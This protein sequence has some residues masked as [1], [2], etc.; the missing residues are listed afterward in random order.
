MVRKALCL[1]AFC[2]HGQ[3]DERWC[4][5][6]ATY[7]FFWWYKAGQKQTLL[8]LLSKCNDNLLMAN[9][10]TVCMALLA[11]ILK[12]PVGVRTA[13]GKAVVLAENFRR[14]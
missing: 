12:D 5:A 7:I 11:H 10:V 9:V 3:G 8:V 4:P 13:R 14:L 6:M 1:F 2:C